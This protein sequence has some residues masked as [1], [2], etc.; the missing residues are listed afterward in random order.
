MS[1]RRKPEV[2]KGRKSPAAP[3]GREASTAGRSTPNDAA[4]TLLTQTVGGQRRGHEF[5][6]IKVEHTA[7]VAPHPKLIVGRADDPLEKEADRVADQ[8]MRAPASGATAQAGQKSDGPGQAPHDTRATPDGSPVQ[9]QVA[10]DAGG[11]LPDSTREYFESRL[12]HD[13]GRVRVHTGLRA[14]DAAH[15][16]HA[17]AFTVGH[18]VVFGAGEYTPESRDGRTLLAH[19]LAHVVQQSKGAT[20]NDG[21]GIQRKELTQEGSAG[22]QATDILWDVAKGT[23][24]NLAEEA[25]ENAIPPAK[26]AIMAIKIGAAF[27][28]GTESGIYRARDRL[29]SQTPSWEHLDEGEAGVEAARYERLWQA[30]A[31][32]EL[33]EV[34]MEGISSA[35]GQALSLLTEGIVESAIEPLEPALTEAGDKI[36]DMVGDALTGDFVDAIDF[37]S[38]AS[39]DKVQDFIKDST[40]PFIQA[41]YQAAASTPIEHGWT[42]FQTR[43]YLEAEGGLPPEEAAQVAQA[44]A[45]S[46]MQLEDRCL[47]EGWHHQGLG[48]YE[49]R[50]MAERAG[51]IH[52]RHGSSRPKEATSRED[53]HSR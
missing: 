30:R 51:Q 3:R 41:F 13:F 10:M 19:E 50:G 27:G 43:M 48:R 17:R 34:L 40:V 12:G 31:V 15:A 18:N 1:V 29:R 26:W 38:Q 5:G 46:S 49:K 35:L 6:R 45:M 52:H 53:G 4:Q 47:R 28:D 7:A 22:S 24:Q 16:M 14:V 9:Q 39:E 44:A 37:I 21:P 36:G 20:S 32:G 23:A 33:N 8:A 11:P 2:R 25:V 42:E